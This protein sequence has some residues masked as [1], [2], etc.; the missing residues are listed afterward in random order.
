M[1]T[2]AHN[3]EAICNILDFYCK[4]LVVSTSTLCHPQSGRELLSGCHQ[5]FIQY[6]CSCPPYLDAI[7]S[8]HNMMMHHMA[9]TKSPLNMDHKPPFLV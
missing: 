4:E 8:M 5:L 3:S 7:S 9:V 1:F 2:R 6:I